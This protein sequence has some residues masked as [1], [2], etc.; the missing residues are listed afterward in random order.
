MADGK[1]DTSK[2]GAVELVDEE[3]DKVQAGAGAEL[4]TSGDDGPA[5]SAGSSKDPAYHTVKLEIIK[6][7]SVPFEQ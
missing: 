1:K 4:R 2:A 5:A 7:E 3:L 6:G